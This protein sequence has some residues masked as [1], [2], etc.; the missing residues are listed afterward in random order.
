MRIA[1][2]ELRTAEGDGRSRRSPRT[3]PVNPLMAI[4]KVL[5][6][7]RLTV[8]LFAFSIGLVFFGTL[9]QK[10]AGIG[11]V[12]DRYFW[13]WGVL[14][15]LQ[16]TLEFGKIFFS[17]P[18][19]AT[20]P[21]WMKLPF[22]GGKLIGALMFINL[23]AA[24]ATRFRLSW[25][26]TG[27]WVAHSGIMLLFIGEAVTR[28][29][30]VEQRMTIHEGES[31]NYTED[32]RNYELAFTTSDGEGNDR[33]TVVPGSAL[34]KSAKR[35]QRIKHDDLP[36]DIEVREYMANSKL[37]DPAS[38]RNPTGAE[39][40]ANAGLGKDI[41]ALKKDEVSGVDPN[42]QI[43]LPSAYV[44]LYVKD[45]DNPLGTYLVSLW[46]TF[47]PFERDSSKAKQSTK[48]DGK[49]YDL[50]FRSTRYYKP[51]KLQLV[52]FKFDR[53]KGTSSAKNYSSDLILDD[54]EREQVRDVHVAMNEPLRY[55]G[56]TF[57][58]SN[59]DKETE[60]TTIL[61]VVRNPGW[62]I[63]YVSC[64]MVTV[65]LLFHFLLYLSQYLLRKRAIVREGSG[66]KS[67]TEILLPCGLVA[68]GVLFLLAQA[69]PRS[70]GETPNLKETG[71]LPVVEG[72]RVK[73]LDT[74]ARVYLRKISGREEVVLDDGTKISA[75]KWLMDVIS[76]PPQSKGPAWKYKVIRIENDQVLSLLGLTRR[77]GYRYSLD[78]IEGKIPELKSAVDK[79]KGKPERK[80]PK[81]V[82]DAK[83]EES[84]KKFFESKDRDVFEAKVIETAERI[85]LY[86]K[87]TTRA[88]PLMLPPGDF[89]N[90]HRDALGALIGGHVGQMSPASRDW[91]SYGDLN[92]EANQVAREAV[93]GKMV[94]TEEM[95]ARMPPQQRK[96][97]EIL[98]GQFETVRR[99]FLEQDPHALQLYDLF[100]AYRAN[101]DGRYTKSLTEF[102]KATEPGVSESDRRKVRFEVFLN[103]FAPA[104]Q[105]IFLYGLAFVV[106]ATGWLT[107]AFEPRYGL[108]VRR[109]AFWLLV[110]TLVIHTFALFSRMYLMD[111]PLVFVTNLYSSAVFIGWAAVGV[112]LV[113]ERIFP[114]GLGNAVASVI[115]FS[116][117][118][119][120]H[121]L[122]ASG[123]TLEM[124]QAVLDTN[125]WLATH[126]TT[127]TLGYSATY[128]AGFFGLLYVGLGVFTTLLKRPVGPAPVK[129]GTPVEL[130]KV[131]GQVMYGIVC[132]ATLLSFVGTVLGGIWADQS[133][134][135]FWGWDP[136][137]NG[138]VLIVIWNALI[139][140][141]R[142]SGLT[143]D[144]GTAILAIA[145]IMITTWSWFGTN[146]LGVG[147]HAYGFSNQLALGCAITWVAC[148]G[149]IGLGLIPSKYWS[150]LAPGN[151]K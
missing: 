52:K 71:N 79:I 15:E 151:R 101:D 48:V 91:T 125:F 19:D 131:L 149:C 23:V 6:S 72:G 86:S 67:L 133:W 81:G 38:P 80:G 54:P 70:T 8:A 88:A 49:V 69:A 85:E 56:E 61:Q 94:I 65:G 122:A 62:I 74:V 121:N 148:L 98:M 50:A 22:P 144:R 58:Q 30:Q 99:E 42:Q 59:F 137:E 51:Y 108:A 26:R 130:G 105:V 135:R 136:K 24:H 37:E 118:I 13:S 2:P 47:N 78:E 55:R 7:L 93:F 103:E 110:L 63:P 134:G 120:A 90:P 53:Y 66:S 111:R 14:V 11:T 127:V 84:V 115:G 21:S 112:C 143:K 95:L 145:G 97:F 119:I 104:Y 106:C 82:E 68:F 124:M 3:R 100:T 18:K 27:I 116:T 39:N 34:V 138:A 36:V 5:A 17:L 32:T 132:L 20:A 76:A 107:S 41:V 117:A 29:F 28:E 123:D 146:Q 89:A 10:T 96:Q 150:S 126:V 140:H 40:P 147:L 75:M 102:K 142:W 45:T 12:V 57:Y 31:T 129:G 141:A 33:V 35:K 64:G 43:D 92:Q 44:T 25:K 77:E 4:V 1:P 16:P 109:G 46:F 9:A 139:L 60:T 87:L 128:V 73:P 113:L 114:L 83:V